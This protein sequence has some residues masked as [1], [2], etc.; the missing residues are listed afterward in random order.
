MVQESIQNESSLTLFLVMDQ[1]INVIAVSTYYALTDVQGTVWGYADTGD[2]V[3]ARWT[4]DAW[5]NV[6]DED[7]SVP[8]LATLR[9]RFQGREWSQI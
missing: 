6:L 2:N 5:G 9:Y 3:V 8:A 4:Y 1:F 7:V